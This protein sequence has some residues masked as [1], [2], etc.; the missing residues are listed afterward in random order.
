MC[1]AL[2]KAQTVSN[3]LKITYIQEGGGR[4]DTG[5]RTCSRPHTPTEQSLPPPPTDP[6][7]RAG[8]AQSLSLP[9]GVVAPGESVARGSLPGGSNFA[10]AQAR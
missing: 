3:T 7:S 1:Q 10:A 2:A 9:D 6:P 5:E 8:P 4:E